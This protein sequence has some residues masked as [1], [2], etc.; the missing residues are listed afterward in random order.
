MQILTF[1]S[2]YPNIM[3]PRHGIFA[4]NRMDYFDRIEGTSRKVIAPVQYM[5]LLGL[6]PRS[7][8]HK[9]NRIPERERQGDVAV[10]H[11][12]YITIPGTSLINVA[13]AMA[14]SARR[15]VKKIYA[16]E[17]IFDLIDGHYLYPDGVAAHRLAREYNKPLVLTALGSDVNFWLEQPQHKDSIL[18]AINYAS[19]VTCVSQS[20][21]DRLIDH[22]ISEDKLAVLLNGIDQSVFNTGVRPD[23]PNSYLLTIGNLIPL[24]GH[25]FILRSLKDFPEE[26]LVII[27]S[28]EL[29]NNLKTLA[30]RLEISHRVTFLPN[31]PQKDLAPYYAGAK[32]TILMSSM[33]GMPN[34]ILE[35]LA[36]GTP[37]IAT[38]VGGIPEVVTEDNGILLPARD[39]DALTA[40]LKDALTRNWDREK[41]SQGIA[42][43][44]W[45]E[46]ACK[47]HDLFSTILAHEK[48]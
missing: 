20:L 5:P 33:E 21:K 32:V 28:G 18:A 8:Y 9:Y 23:G 34:V 7:R 2:L 15:V 10:Y 27:G 39:T 45:S 24:K 47:L 48:P 14:K 29:E 40:A 3:E 11:P 12:R 38:N 36:S 37:V 41:I 42:Y 31:I 26:R 1:T 16:E 35:S 4:K 25:E 43:L 13:N 46:T 22:G 30:A 6:D 17:D 19:K 44:D